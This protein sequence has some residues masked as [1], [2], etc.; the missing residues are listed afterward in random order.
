MKVKIRIINHVIDI[1]DARAATLK[2]SN[3]VFTV[4]ENLTT[5][6]SVI[7]KDNDFITVYVVRYKENGPL[8]MASRDRGGAQIIFKTVLSGLT[9]QKHAMIKVLKLAQKRADEFKDL[10]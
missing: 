3:G 7:H 5:M 2:V 10:L 6:M 4:S 9:N 8:M 1:S